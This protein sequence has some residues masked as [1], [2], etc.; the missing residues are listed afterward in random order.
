MKRH[1]PR[2]GQCSCAS[3][4]NRATTDAEVRCAQGSGL[5]V[6][7]EQ[8]CGEALLDKVKGARAAHQTLR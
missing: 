8:S 6:G 4:D 5:S 2:A 7:V 1:L 3:A